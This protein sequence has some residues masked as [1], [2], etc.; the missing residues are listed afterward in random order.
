MHYL[1]QP[2]SRPTN[3]PISVWGTM[4]C[5]PVFYGKIYFHAYRK[6]ERKVETISIVHEIHMPAKNALL[7]EVVLCQISV[8]EWSFCEH[9]YSTKQ[10]RVEFNALHDI[11]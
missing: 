5:G 10:N 9:T 8:H 11:Q 1:T 7:K 6:R 4:P 2:D 3:L